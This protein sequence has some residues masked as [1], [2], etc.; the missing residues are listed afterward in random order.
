MAA[1]Q[2]INHAVPENL[3]TVLQNWGINVA[4]FLQKAEAKEGN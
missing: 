4:T 2:K 1:I 3:L